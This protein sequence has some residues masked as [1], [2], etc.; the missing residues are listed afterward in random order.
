MFSNSLF[1]FKENKQI[2]LRDLKSFSIFWMNLRDACVWWLTTNR[3]RICNGLSHILK[4]VCIGWLIFTALYHVLVLT[5]PNK[6]KYFS[7]YPNG[8]SV[9]FGRIFVWYWQVLLFCRI[10]EVPRSIKICL[11]FSHRSQY[12]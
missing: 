6:W 1:F 2:K 12:F 10:F 4:W 8:R 9:K 3:I 11:F 5:P 7:N